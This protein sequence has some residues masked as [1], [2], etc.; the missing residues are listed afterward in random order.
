MNVADSIGATATT[1]AKTALELPFGAW[2]VGGIGAVAL[3]IVGLALPTSFLESLSFQLYLDTIVAAA[4]AP[5]GQ[6][7]KLLFALGFAGLGGLIGYALARLFHVRASEGGFSAI[8]E[9]LRGGRDDDEADAPVLRSADRHPDAPARR[10]FSAARDIPERGWFSG[11]T[12]RDEGDGSDESLDL[13]AIAKDQAV[14]AGAAPAPVMVDD[15]DDELLLD[16]AFFDVDSQPAISQPYVQPAAPLDAAPLDDDLARFNIR[17]GAMPDDMD[18]FDIPAPRLTDW[19]VSEEPVEARIDAPFESVAPASVDA[20]APVVAPAMPVEPEFAPIVTAKPAT[21]AIPPHDPLDLSA[22]RLED[23]LARLET[24]LSRRT[25]VAEAAVPDAVLPQH[26]HSDA[27]AVGPE[28]PVEAMAQSVAQS[29]A[30]SEARPADFTPPS[31]SPAIATSAVPTEAGANDPAFPHDPA[32]AAALA[33]L[34]RLNQR[35]S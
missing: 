23:L 1:R 8:L 11:F 7:A 16:G 21:M 25:A 26:A 14:S 30:Q 6:T 31:A 10:P 15:D 35:A 13:A 12:S 22:A 32:L 17:S 3:G 20:V 19:D 29:A 5:L 9:R 24:G 34:R 33:T 4:K 18:G 28:S 27:A 2:G